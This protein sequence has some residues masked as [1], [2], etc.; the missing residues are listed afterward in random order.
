MTKNQEKCLK[1]LHKKGA[2]TSEEIC[3][4]LK[5]K[6]KY[7]TATHYSTVLTEL[8]YLNND[9]FDNLVYLVTY[10]LEEDP[11]NEHATFNLSKAGVE[12]FANNKQKRSEKRF[13]KTALLISF[14]S[15]VCAC[16]GIILTI[17]K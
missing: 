9:E 7:E 14:L 12:F 10:S 5:I 11:L 8:P 1:L 4:K 6:I 2:L 17:I 3:K 16:V 13:N 15:L